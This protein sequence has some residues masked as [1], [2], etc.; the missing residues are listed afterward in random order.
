MPSANNAS[1][2][3]PPGVAASLRTVVG[4]LGRRPGATALTVGLLLVN[5]CIEL[6]LPQII[7]ETINGLRSLPSGVSPRGLLVVTAGLYLAMVALRTCVGLILGPLRNQTAQRTLGDLRAAVYEA[8]QRQTFA[9]H[10]NARTGELISRASTDIWRL[11]DFMFVCL[12]FSVDAAAGMIGTT[13]LIFAVKPSLGWIA[14][15]TLVPTLGALAFYAV[16]LQ[17]K[18]RRVHDR[19]S[20]MSTVI[21]ENI[22][23]ARVVRAFARE[24]G[25]LSKFRAKKESYLVELLS[26]VN[27]WAVRAPAAQFLFGLAAPLTLWIGGRQVIR[28]SLALGDLAKV[29]LYLL[30]LGGRIGLIGQ[31]TNILQNAGSSAQRIREV[32]DATVAMVEGHR[33]FP[34]EAGESAGAIRFRTASLKYHREPSLLVEGVEAEES[35]R[36]VPEATSAA[37]PAVDQVDFEIRAGETVAVVGATGSGKSS[38]LALIPR[39][40]DATEGAVEVNGIDVR[41]LRA[42]DLRRAV[43]VVF[44]ESFLFSASIA[45]NIAFGRPDATR[46]E[47]EAAARMAR[48]DEFIRELAQGYETVVGERGTSLSGGQR[49]RIAIARAL[50]AEPKILLLDDATSAIDPATEREILE[51]ISAFGRG[52]TVVIVTQRLSTAR[53]ADR[54]VVLERGRIVEQGAPVELMSRSG[55]F[56]A[57]FESQSARTV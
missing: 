9:W 46:R 43:A 10:D 1:A 47:I 26:T 19:H 44:Q 38:L 18:W 3:K 50:L 11:Q 14:V 16:R 35:P 8:L 22:A 28:G 2:K 40:Y 5:I 39:F 12:L 36:K 24:G 7:G 32:L 23:G 54:V 57:L 20:A 37:Q 6:S 4:F 25:E 34:A 49:Q 33:G 51:S 56:A 42:S 30:G 41:E 27:Y 15:G 52:R 45:E 53:K 17:P 29:V 13:A 31:I 21:Q 55:P 48:A